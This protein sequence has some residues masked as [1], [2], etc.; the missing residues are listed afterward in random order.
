MDQSNYLN[1]TLQTEDY[2]N[3]ST[4]FDSSEYTNLAIVK[5]VAGCISFIVCCLVIVLIVLLKKWKF[6]SQ[7]LIL[8]LTI[9]ALLSSMANILNRVDFNGNSSDFLTEFCIFG[10]FFTQVSA[11]MTLNAVTGITIYLFSRAILNKNTDKYEWVYLAFIFII[12]FLFNW[13][14]F[15]HNSYGSAGVWCWIRSFDHNTC[16]VLIFGHWLQFGLLYIPVYTI[17]AVMLGLY[18][19]IIISICHKRKSVV[20]GNNSQRNKVIRKMV[21]EVIVLL[22]YPLI[23]FFLNIPLLL[24]R[25]YTSARPT[26]P[27]LLLWYLSGLFIPLQGTLTGLAFIFS[28]DV[29]KKNLWTDF[30]AKVRGRSRIVREYPMKTTQV[31][32]SV[33]FCSITSTKHNCVEY[34]AY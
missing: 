17:L 30:V 4:P 29:C 7:R 26:E 27:S 16:E 23:Y 1:Q 25:I 13:I 6:F 2:I 33:E 18:I 12:P 14:P 15:I 8:Y 32:D 3:C 5:Q 9:S 20:G 19:L 34:S 22:A 11:W 24:N 10:G 28:L 21:S 31:S